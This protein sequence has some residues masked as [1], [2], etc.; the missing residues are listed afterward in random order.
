MIVKECNTHKVRKHA[1][2]HDTGCSQPK[3]DLSMSFTTSLAG[4]KC[5]SLDIRSGEQV[6]LFGEQRDDY[7][8]G[9][10]INTRI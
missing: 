10:E 6:V 1:R 4:R 2:N 9:P 5:A 3:R 8:Q 7:H